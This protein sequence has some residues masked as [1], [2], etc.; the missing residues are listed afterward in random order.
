MRFVA[1]VVTQGA[2]PAEAIAEMNR[3]WP[4]Y[5]EEMERRG[6][7]PAS[8]PTQQELFDRFQRSVTA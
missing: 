6:P 1:L 2:M 3:D 8:E 4:A 7:T 5:A